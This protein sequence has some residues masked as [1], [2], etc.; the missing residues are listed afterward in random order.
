M[1]IDF[2]KKVYNKLNTNVVNWVDYNVTCGVIVGYET[3]RYLATEGFNSPIDDYRVRIDLKN[4]YSIGITI[5]HSGSRDKDKVTNVLSVDAT[6]PGVE[7]VDDGDGVVTTWPRRVMKERMN[8]VEGEFD[9]DDN[10][11]VLDIMRFMNK[12]ATKE[13]A[14]VEVVKKVYNHE[15][16]DLLEGLGMSG[17]DTFSLAELSAIYTSCA[18]ERDLGHTETI[19][20]EIGRASNESAKEMYMDVM[21]ETLE[22]YEE[23]EK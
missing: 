3:N 8:F 2:V 19:D 14:D 15:I 10:G 11:W 16:A 7:K 6:G 20:Q 13:Q 17:K 4:G 23:E 22:D 21:R 18:V 12:Y 9:I 5:M 1:S